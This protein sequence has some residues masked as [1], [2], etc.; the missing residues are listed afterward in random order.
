MYVCV[1]FQ[2]Q[3]SRD[4]NINLFP[5]FAGHLFAQMPVYI[6]NPVFA[7][8]PVCLFL[9]L[10]KPAFV[11]IVGSMLPCI[12]N[13]LFVQ[14]CNHRRKYLDNCPPVHLSL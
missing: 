1:H 6:F 13:S 12:S 11:Q 3:L 5:C 8:L 7:C 14:F 10:L 9:Y 2:M 4:M